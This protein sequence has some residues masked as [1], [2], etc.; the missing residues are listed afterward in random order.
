MSMFNK[1]TT[2]ALVAIAIASSLIVASGLLGSAFAAIKDKSSKLMDPTSP[3]TNA[4]GEEKS[5]SQGEKTGSSSTSSGDTG[6]ISKKDLK[7]LLKCQS[8]A[9]EDGDLTLVE[10]KDCYGQAFSQGQNKPDESNGAQGNNQPENLHEQPKSGY[11]LEPK[12]TSM[13]EGF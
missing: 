13:R 7:T 2:A 4:S 3:M 10:V 6:G 12:I 1:R 11:L 5:S 9:A 8:G